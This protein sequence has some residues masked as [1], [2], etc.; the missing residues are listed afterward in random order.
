[1]LNKSFFTNRPIVDARLEGLEP[2]EQFRPNT[3]EII[4]LFGAMGLSPVQV[5]YAIKGFTGTLP[6]ALLRLLDPV[7]ASSEVV[8]PEMKLEEA[9]IIGSLFQPE[10]A[11]GIINAAF[12]RAGNFQRAS[13]TYNK[14]LEDGRE[15]EAERYLQENLADIDLASAGGAF[16]QE[17]GELTKEEREIR[18]SDMSP[19]EKRERLKEIRK[20]KIALSRDF[21][22]VSEQIKSQSGL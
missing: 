3:P 5:E 6:V 1:M 18:G 15:E 21:T 17:M 9:P 20:L 13:N 19:E 8:K 7:F 11:G 4:K 2:S 14:M 22:T 12:A 10:D 16:R